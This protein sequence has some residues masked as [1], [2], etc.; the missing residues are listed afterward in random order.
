M[1]SAGKVAVEP[2]TLGDEIENLQASEIF[3]LNFEEEWQML[4]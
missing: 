4:K 1:Y 2:G 3:A